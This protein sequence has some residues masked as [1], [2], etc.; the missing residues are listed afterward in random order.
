MAAGFPRARADIDQRA[1]TLAITLR[2][3][4][5]EIDRFKAFL[6]TVPDADLE[7]AP[8]L[9]SGEDV[10]YLKSAFADLARLGEIFRGETTQPQAYDFRTFAQHLA[11]V[12]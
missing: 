6:D 10:A 8:I 4:F 1:G 12:L 2:N 5:D 3:T 9:Y 7:A 11:G